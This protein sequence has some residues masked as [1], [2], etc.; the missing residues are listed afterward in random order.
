MATESKANS[1]SI[2]ARI[3]GRK[4]AEETIGEAMDEGPDFADGF[5]K[6]AIAMMPDHIRKQIAIDQSLPAMDDAQAKRFESKA[7]GFGSLAK[8]TYGEADIDYLQWL[9]DASNDLRAY[10]RSERGKARTE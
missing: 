6:T 10:L 5:W 1:E 3:D 9:A 4:W 7:I 2:Q 8:S